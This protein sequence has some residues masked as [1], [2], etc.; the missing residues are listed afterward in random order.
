[1]KFFC[2]LALCLALLAQ[3]EP[4]PT[5]NGALKGVGP[6]SLTLEEEAGNTLE[7]RLTKKT[8]CYDGSKAVKPSALKPGRQLAIDAKRDLDGTL[9]AVTVRAQ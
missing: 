2:A 5:F 6:H 1:M 7:F 8:R 9:E 3:T 4:L